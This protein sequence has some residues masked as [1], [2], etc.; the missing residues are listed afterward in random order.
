LPFFVAPP[1][2]EGDDDDVVD[3]TPLVENNLQD[4]E[5]IKIFHTSSMN[6][7]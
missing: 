3:E 4:D 5:V 2:D 1:R 6:G 7:L